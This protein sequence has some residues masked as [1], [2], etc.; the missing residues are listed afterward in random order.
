M[1]SLVASFK[2]QLVD[3]VSIAKQ[4]NIKHSKLFNHIVITGLGGSGIGGS[5][6]K[7]LV[8][9]SL[10][11]P[12]TSNKGYCLPASVNENTLVIVSSFSGNTEETVICMNEAI[13]KGASIFCITSGGIV[14]ET[15]KEKEL[16]YIQL[17]T[18]N[19]PRAMLSYS[20]TQLLFALKAYDL[21]EDIDVEN[22]MNKAI[23]FIENST[24][25]IQKEAKEI[26]EFFYKKKPVLYSVDGYDGVCERF[27]QQI[28]ENAK[29]LCWHHIVPEMN[30]NELVGWTENHDDL[31][32]LFMK[33]KDDHERNTIRMNLN[34]DIISKY[35]QVKEY[36]SLGENQLENTLYW[37]HLGDWVSV[38]L[39]EMNDVDPIE[40]NVIDFLK[41]ELGKA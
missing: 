37:I 33:N 14:L 3:A 8:Y 34:R 13:A 29:M 18:A 32:V 20:V 25:D 15:A 30:H 21:L 40:V 26:A 5:I 39:S 10:K 1:K 41:S 6:V 27:R 22:M 24:L 36:T 4:I 2:N 11:M 23:G 28:N 9:N 17:P 38:Y 35:A 16:D 7:D 31:A 12:I 19:S